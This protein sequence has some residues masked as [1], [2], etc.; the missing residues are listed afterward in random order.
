M[1][2]EKDDYIEKLKGSSRITASPKSNSPSQLMSLSE[3]LAAKLARFGP[4]TA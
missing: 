2:K 1:V 3:G 4:R